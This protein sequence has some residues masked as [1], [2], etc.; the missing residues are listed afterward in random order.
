MITSLD[1]YNKYGDP[2]KQKFVK[3]LVIWNVPKSLQVGNI[4]KRVYCHPDMIPLLTKA[5]TNLIERGK[6]HELKTW[7]GCWNMRPIRGCEKRYADAVKAGDISLAMKYLSKHAF[8]CAIDVNAAE[9][10]LGVEPKLSPEFVKCF[11]D[12]GFV[13]GGHFKRKD[14]MH[15]EMAKLP[16]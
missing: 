12:A 3:M 2:G 1:L 4:P 14:G 6:V 11:T 15:F 10:G 8:A 7:D 13:W 9:N 16:L 5:F